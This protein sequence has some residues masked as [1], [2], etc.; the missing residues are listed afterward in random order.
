MKQRPILLSCVAALLL[1]SLERASGAEFNATVHS[2]AARFM[3][4]GLELRECRPGAVVTLNQI[5]LPILATG[6]PK[7]LA[8]NR[9]QTFLG[10]GIERKYAW[11]NAR[12]L[13]L[14]W[15]LTTLDSGDGILLKTSIYNGSGE[16]AR[17]WE[18][19]MIECAPQ[20]IRFSDAGSNWLLSALSDS[21]QTG[22]LEG[23]GERS[24]QD[25][26]GIYRYRDAAGLAFGAVVFGRH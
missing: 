5:H 13:T 6:K 8:E 11:E 23:K 16:A 19:S 9:V 15:T 2:D 24:F 22:P 4:D 3:T 14:V 10:G 25:Y 20:S 17:L 12:H 26:M 7:L 1:I 18:L 21:S